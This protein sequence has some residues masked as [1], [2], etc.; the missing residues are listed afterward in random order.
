M[1]LK[2]RKFISC[3][4]SSLVIEGL[5]EVR[6]SYWA[7]ICDWI[8]V[9]SDGCSHAK[10]KSASRLAVIERMRARP[11]SDTSEDVSVE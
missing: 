2:G 9:V 8:F 5:F 1:L 4:C 6:C 7:V 11:N 3:S 10:R